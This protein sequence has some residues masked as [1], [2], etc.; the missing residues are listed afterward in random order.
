LFAIDTANNVLY[1]YIDTE[2]KEF[3]I[4]SAKFL[5]GD[6]VSD[7]VGVEPASYATA[8]NIHNFLDEEVFLKKRALIANRESDN[9]GTVSQYI[10]LPMEPNTAVEIDSVDICTL[11]GMLFPPPKFIKGFIEIRSPK[12]LNVIAVYTAKTS[13]GLSLDVE[14]ISPL[15]GDR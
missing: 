7:N 8:I 3:F 9:V 5:C 12:P 2:A 1:E 13:G 10:V 14:H 11:L 6:A 15:E 4:Y